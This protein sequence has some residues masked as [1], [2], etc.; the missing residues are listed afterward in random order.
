MQKKKWVSHK[1]PNLLHKTRD[2]LMGNN[3]FKTSNFKTYSS[4]SSGGINFDIFWVVWF[5]ICSTIHSSNKIP[6]SLS[7][8]FSQST[9]FPLFFFQGS[10]RKKRQRICRTSEE[11]KNREKFEMGLFLDIDWRRRGEREGLGKFTKRTKGLIANY[12]EPTKQRI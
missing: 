6:L 5:R 10:E 8:Y 7:I 1:N 12:S 2:I 11:K 4:I 9:M 3:G